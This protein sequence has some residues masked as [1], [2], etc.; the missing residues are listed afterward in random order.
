MN[1]VLTAI[2]DILEASNLPATVTHLRETV[3]P[4]IIIGF[5]AFA[6]PDDHDRDHIKG[7]IERLFENCAFGF[8]DCDLLYSE[9]TTHN[10][11]DH[12]VEVHLGYSRS[13]CEV[14]DIIEIDG[15]LV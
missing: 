10:G 12:E 6:V 13:Q 2:N 11:G 5:C 1:A 3:K 9:F 15:Y 14:P 4:D 7:L 8:P